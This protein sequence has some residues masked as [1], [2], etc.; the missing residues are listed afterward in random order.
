MSFECQRLCRGEFNCL[1]SSYVSI[2]RDIDAFLRFRV[3][4]GSDDFSFPW[5][6]STKADYPEVLKEEGTRTSACPRS[7]RE[8]SVGCQVVP[9]KST[10]NDWH[11]A[12][13]E[14]KSKV[15]QH[16]KTL[17]RVY[18]ASTSKSQKG[19]DIVPQ[20]FPSAKPD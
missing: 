8:S 7:P 17:Y 11:R 16:L 3:F 13:I 14:I 4:T 2:S 6:Y 20:I 9:K 10:P 15:S 19:V 5:G 18:L 12:R 1:S